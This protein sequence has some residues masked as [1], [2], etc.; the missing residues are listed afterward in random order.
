[1][2]STEFARTSY[3]DSLMHSANGTG[4]RTATHEARREV[5]TH[6]CYTPLLHAHPQPEHP[7]VACVVWVHIVV[8][9]RLPAVREPRTFV[10]RVDIDGITVRKPWDA[11]ILQKDMRSHF[12][13]AGTACPTA[14][15]KLTLKL[16]R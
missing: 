15:L 11:V 9:E 10:R 6:S 4:K 7:P 2:Q 12:R 8:A 1:M 16:K 5:P 14:T 3:T 13:G